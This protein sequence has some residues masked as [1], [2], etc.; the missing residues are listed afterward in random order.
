MKDDEDTPPDK[1]TY[2]TIMNGFARSGEVRRAG[3]ILQQMYN[4][5]LQGNAVLAPDLRTFNTVLGAYAKSDLPDAPDQAETFLYDMRKLC[6]QGLLNIQPD[7]YTISSGT[8]PN[9]IRRNLQI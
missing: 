3:E 7:A 9:L 8:L 6:D 5:Y 2:T 4:E 1:I